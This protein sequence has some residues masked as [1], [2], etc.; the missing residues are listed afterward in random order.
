[1]KPLFFVQPKSFDPGEFLK[2]PKLVRRWDD[3][4]YLVNL[5]LWK[6]SRW[7]VNDVGEGDDRGVVRLQAKYLMRVMRQCD[8]AEVIKTLLECGVIERFAYTIGEHSFGYR[9]AARFIHDK[10]VRVPVTDR[11][12]IKRLERLR[13]ERAAKRQALMKPVHHELERRQRQLRID[14]DLAREILSAF[15]ESNLYDRQGILISAIEHRDFHC[16]VGNYGRFS[17]NITSLKR[18]VRNALNVGNEQLGS[19]DVSCTQPAL[20]AKLMQQQFSITPQWQQTEQDTS[21]SNYDSRFGP[22]SHD[23]DRYRSLAQSGK[24]YDVLLAEL[25]WP[26]SRRDELKKCLLRDVF[27]KRGWYRSPVEETFR[28]LFLIVWQYI[29]AINCGGREHVNLIRRLQQ[30]ESKFVIETVAA[31]LMWRLPSV[32]IVSLHDALFC[33]VKYLQDVERAFHRAFE[34]TGFEMSLKTSA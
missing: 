21:T 6:L 5:I 27:A 31:D 14:G 32:C 15:P 30:E 13:V 3:A 11:R 19:V 10:H 20:T 26:L 24:L 29:Q 2:T 9:L 23:F 1:M 12:L 4:R 28:R 25:G 33:P 22:G 7:D 16:N 18:E 17:N 34:Q 8:Y